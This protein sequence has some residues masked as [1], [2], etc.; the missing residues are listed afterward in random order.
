MKKESKNF[1]DKVRK[2]KHKNLSPNYFVPI[3]CSTPY[4]DGNEEH[5]LDCGVYI[6]ECKC[7]YNDGLSGWPQARWKERKV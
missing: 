7:H 6:S 2:C 4:C 1:W 3:Y 5:C